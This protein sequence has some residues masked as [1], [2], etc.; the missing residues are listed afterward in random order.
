MSTV[1][2]FGERAVYIAL[3]NPCLGNWL[4]VPM[5]TKAEVRRRA[6]A[7]LQRIAVGEPVDFFLL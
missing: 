5:L 1:V 4:R 7:R 3:G 6:E 2:D